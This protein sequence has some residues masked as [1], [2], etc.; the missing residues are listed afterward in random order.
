VNLVKSVDVTSKHDY[1]AKCKYHDN[2]VDHVC[3]T[4]NGHL[5]LPQEFVSMVGIIENSYCKLASRL[6]LADTSSAYEAYKAGIR[7]TMM[8]NME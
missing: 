3:R 7:Q 5:L 2:Y 1:F 4:P 6:L 8:T